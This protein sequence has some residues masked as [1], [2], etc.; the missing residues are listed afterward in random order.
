M[1]YTSYWKGSPGKTQKPSKK[2]PSA[3]INI[4]RTPV[5]SP[6]TLMDANSLSPP[7]YPD[8]GPQA[9]LLQTPGQSSTQDPTG[10]PMVTLYSSL[11]R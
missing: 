6:W 5:D 10:Y 9:S 11:Y 3:A 4:P 1:S 7:T 2:D 8:V